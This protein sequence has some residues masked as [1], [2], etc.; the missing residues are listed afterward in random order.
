MSPSSVSTS[1]MVRTKR[2]QWAPLACNNGASR[3]TVT[4]VAR[5][6]VISMV[7]LSMPNPGYS[8]GQTRT[9]SRV[10]SARLLG[11]GEAARE[12]G[13]QGP[14]GDHVEHD[15]GDH[16]HDGQG[17]EESPIHLGVGY[18]GAEHAD[19]DRHLAL[20]RDQD[21]R[22]KELVPGPDKADQAARGHPWAGEGQD[23]P[24][25]CGKAVGA[26]HP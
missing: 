21:Q 10:R 2:P 12:G 22:D 18:P 20:I 16:V 8:L 9:P 25:R 11:A 7:F 14:T 5:T 17:G 6:S 23:Y 24:K 1:T 15:G 19:R 26:V 3:G 4:V 13:L